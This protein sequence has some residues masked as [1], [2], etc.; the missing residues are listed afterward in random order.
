MP[1]SRPAVEAAALATLHQMIRQ[2]VGRVSR[3]AQAVVWWLEGQSQ[4]AVAQRLGVCRQSVGRWCARFQHEGV[5]GLPDR[6]RSGRP[7]RLG[8]GGQQYLRSLLRQSDLP[9]TTGPGGWTATRLQARL[10]LLDWRVSVRT[11]RRWLPRLGAR[12]RRGKPT[13][14]GDPQ[15]REVLRR[16]AAGLLTAHLAALRAG[17]RLVMVF[18]DEADLALL[19]H[20]GYSWQLA[21]QPATIPTPGQNQQVGLFGSLSVDGE[22]V[23]TVAPRKTAV[24]L[25]DHLEQVLARFP[26]AV[27]A[28]ILDN[29]G[30]HRATH[31][32]TWLARHPHV[33][34]LPLPRYS[35]QDNAQ[36]QVWGWLRAAVCRN[37]AFPD[38]ATKQTAAWTFL[39]TRTPEALRQRCVPDRL[40]TNLLAEAFA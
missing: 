16:L 28:V 4:V 19:A 9:G 1:Q 8:A 20:A 24:A 10:R 23:V 32:K 3:R 17:R 21:D 34:L 30:I 29:G 38:L 13:P 5:A 11:V 6:P 15:R 37:R 27:L 26:Q 2:A 25:T 36:E 7:P 31:T 14:K 40:L 22:L 33:H 39:T 12:W 18:E 35:P